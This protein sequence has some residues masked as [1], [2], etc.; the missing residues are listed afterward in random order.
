MANKVLVVDDEPKIVELLKSRLEDNGYNVAT[1]FDGQEAL[2]RIYQEIP[3]LI[4]MDIILPKI[5]G[6]GVCKALRADDRYKQIPVI[7]LTGRCQAQDIKTG[8]DLGAVCYMQK[9]FKADMLLALIP[10]LIKK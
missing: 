8:M 5:D 1:A 9:P 3:D 4:I 6:Y 7:M 2:D 10:G